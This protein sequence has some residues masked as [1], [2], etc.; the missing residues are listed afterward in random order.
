[1]P[2]STRPNLT[3]SNRS[4]EGLKGLDPRLSRLRIDA[5]RMQSDFDA[6]SMIGSTGDGGVHRPALSAAH[7][8]ARAWFRERVRQAGLAV[9]VDSAGNHSA[10]LECGL[11]AEAPVLLLGS[12]LDSVPHGGRFDGA[13]GV[14][15]A[16]EILRT[17]QEA[18][19][20]GL[21]R[22]PVHLEAIDFTDEE[23]TL[24]GL[25][26]S[27]AAA[28]RLTAEQL[29]APRGGREALLEGLQRAG[30]Q[31]SGL[32]AAR[33]DPSRLAGYLELHIEQG[34]RLLGAGAQIGVVRSI[35]GIVAYRLTFIGRADHAG[36]TPMAD[37][38]DAAQ[39]ASAFL[40]GVRQTV[41]ADFPECVANVG[42]FEIEPGAFNIVPAR[43]TLSLEFRAAQPRALEHLEQVLLALAQ[44]EAARFSLDLQVEPLGR[45]API[46]LSPAARAAV[47]SAAQ[48]LNVRT[49]ALDSGAGHDAQMMAA[50]CP[51]GM[52]FVPSQG[53][54]SHAPREF[55]TWQDCVQGANVLL[56]AALRMAEAA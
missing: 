21:P 34:P 7:L 46:Q 28:G 56:Q 52:L 20:E 22:L 27:S 11:R 31:E 16:L 45:H 53:G 29:L 2:T 43:A 33:R 10:R 55:T 18:Q 30:L 48:A 4:P 24:V 44:G 51:A 23:G 35:V 5:E 49:L 17:V 36:T 15:A 9:Q 37:R 50:V 42:R 32:L 19:S 41:M 26:G 1:M 40:L 12:H 38:L 3:V 6:L 14:V 8:E 39:G 54:A 47:Q 25:L 13:L